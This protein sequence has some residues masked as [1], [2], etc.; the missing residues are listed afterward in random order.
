MAAASMLGSF[1]TAAGVCI[2][3]VCGAFLEEAVLDGDRFVAEGELPRV[4]TFG[5]I[6]ALGLLVLAA[7][8]TVSFP[9]IAAKSTRGQVE[10]S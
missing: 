3:G 2:T 5:A 9:I 6:V 10:I 4:V 8:F 7:D 1:S